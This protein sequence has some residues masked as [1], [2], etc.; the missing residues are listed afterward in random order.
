[1]VPCLS[2]IFKI[3]SAKYSIGHSIGESKKYPIRSLI[4]CIS[5][6]CIIHRALDV[7]Q[8][9]ARRQDHKDRVEL[10]VQEF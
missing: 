4:R 8:G 9:G 1:M 5:T 10:G 2:S 7:Y 6:G 3:L